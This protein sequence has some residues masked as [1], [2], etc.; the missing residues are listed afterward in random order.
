MSMVLAL[1]EKNVVYMATDSVAAAGEITVVSSQ[2]KIFW[3]QEYLIGFCGSFRIGQVVKFCSLP[4]FPKFLLNEFL[5]EISAPENLP[6]ISADEN[7]PKNSAY[8][9]EADR[10]M[11]TEFIPALEDQLSAAG[12]GLHDE[13]GTSLMVAVGPWI[14]VIEPGYQVNSYSLDYAALGVAEQAGLVGLAVQMPFRAGRA[15]KILTNTLDILERHSIYV[16]RPYT[17]AST[18]KHGEYVVFE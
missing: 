14:Y 13:S 3:N 7:L 6:E 2:S 15:S 18:D 12:C 9:Y 8:K 17:V 5:P 10:F 1:R 16:K 11:I 4:T